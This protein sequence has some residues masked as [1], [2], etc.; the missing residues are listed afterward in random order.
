MTTTPLEQRYIR[1]SSHSGIRQAATD[2]ATRAATGVVDTAISMVPLGSALASATGVDREA[3]AAVSGAVSAAAESQGTGFWDQLG[4]IWSSIVSGIVRFLSETL[5]IAS[6][7][8]A[9][10]S[11]LLAAKPSATGAP[12][13]TPAASQ[14][15]ERAAAAARL[16]D[17]TPPPAV[18]SEAVA[19]GIADATLS[20][21]S[22]SGDAARSAWNLA[23][24]TFGYQPSGETPDAFGLRVAGSTH[25]SIVRAYLV[26]HEGRDMT[27]AQRE[28]LGAEAM[29]YAERVSG[30]RVASEREGI[31]TYQPVSGPASGLYAYFGAQATR[32]A[33]NAPLEAGASITVAAAAPRRGSATTTASASDEQA[34][35]A[36]AAAR[37]AEKEERVRGT[38]DEPA[39][40]TGLPPAAST[41]QQGTAR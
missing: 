25:A 14:T 35:L 39:P 27:P 15:V 32:L 24:T 9:T 30:V 20:T 5:G 7:N 12:A 1:A 33:S 21:A 40:P 19:R 26:P 41:K 28:A 6:T 8:T 11:S 34:R 16:S 31:F 23:R 17:N 18:I 10:G 38:A 37:L 3:R 29:Q 4:S 36:A 13:L 2:R 22:V